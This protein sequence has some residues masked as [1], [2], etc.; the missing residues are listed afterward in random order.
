MHPL[1][2]VCPQCHLLALLEQVVA[3]LAVHLEEH[4]AQLRPHE[5]PREPVQGP[6]KGVGLPGSCLSVAD[7]GGA[8][9]LLGMQEKRIDDLLEEL[10]VI[11]GVVESLVNH[12]H[13]LQHLQPPPGSVHASVMT[14]DSSEIHVDAHAIPIPGRQLEAQQRSLSRGKSQG[15]VDLAGRL[16]ARQQ[17]HHARPQRQHKL[18]DPRQQ[19]RVQPAEGGGADRRHAHHGSNPIEAPGGVLQSVPVE[20]VDFAHG[21]VLAAV[22]VPGPCFFLVLPGFRLDVASHL[23]QWHGLLLTSGHIGLGRRSRRA[24]HGKAQCAHRCGFRKSKELT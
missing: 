5:L 21:P 4:Q 17:H 22:I 3:L 12:V 13:L 19:Q 7:Q 2:A 20:A 15:M 1:R 10:L 18:R 14:H 23:L 16:L 6:P 8:F 11:H 24:N 9:P